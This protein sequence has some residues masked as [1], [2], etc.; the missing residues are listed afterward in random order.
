MPERNFSIRNYLNEKNRVP[1][2]DEQPQN[3]EEEAPIEPTDTEKQDDVF[4]LLPINNQIEDSSTVVRVESPSL[5]QEPSFTEINNPLVQAS[6]SQFSVVQSV[7]SG[8]TG[9]THVEPP[10][11]VEINKPFEY[12]SEKESAHGIPPPPPPSG[13]IGRQ[14]KHPTDLYN[15]GAVKPIVSDQSPEK[16]Y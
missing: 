2:P 9:V 5:V 6:T 12:I 13:R 15:R 7:I 11:R 1:T 10:I 16:R 3:E 4:D 8:T 14:R